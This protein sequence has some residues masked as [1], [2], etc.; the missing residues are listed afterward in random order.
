MGEEDYGL[1]VLQGVSTGIGVFDVTGDVI[2][3][4]FLN[5]GYYQMVGQGRDE[6][7]Q[8]FGN[9][10]V[11]AINP[12]DRPGLLKEAKAAIKEGREFTYRFRVLNGK[13]N[14]VW[15]GI[16]AN[17]KPLSDVTERFYAAYYNVDDLISQQER[18]R[19]YSE[20]RDEILDSI[21]GGVAIFSMVNGQLRLNYTN[22]GFFELH[23]GSREFLLGKSL[24]PVTWLLP[25]D[26]EL[27]KKEF[28]AVQSGKKAEG[29]VAYRV[30]GE[31]GKIHWV[32]NQFRPA[33]V[34]NGVPFF[35]ASFTDLDAQKEA[36][37]ERSK[38]RQMYEAAVEE[39]QLV[40]WEFD[41]VNHTLT[42]ADNDFT[43]YD[44][45]KFGLPKSLGNVPS[46]L[47]PFI[48]EAYVKDFLAMY[49]AIEAGAP[50]ASCEVWYKLEKGKEPRCEKISYTT[51]FD[52]KGHPIKAYGIGQN[53]TARKRDEEGYD[54]IRH[55]VMGKLS[56]AVSSTQ[57]NLSR[58]LYLEGYSPYP[59]VQAALAKTTA[60][61]HFAAAAASISDPAIKRQILAEFKCS[62]LLS[63]FERGIDQLTR[64]YPILSSKGE[65]LW[66]RTNLTM[67]QNPHT[68]EIEAIS[69]SNDV[70]IE[71]QNEE[72]LAH[73]ANQSLD[74]I[75][76][77]DLANQRYLME[78]GAW[79]CQEIKQG[80]TMDYQAVQ[81]LLADKY[82][83]DNEKEFFLSATD[84]NR[85]V[86]LLKEQSQYI[87]PYD[88]K[89][90][91]GILKKQLTFSFLG[92][93]QKRILVVQSDVTEAYKKDQERI[94]AL[95][96]AKT[97]ADEANRAKSEFLS[98]MSHDIRTPLNGIIGMSYLASEQ[99]NP[100]K[101]QDCLKKIDT[102]SKYLLSLIN[103]ILDMSKAESKAIELHPEPYSLNEFQAYVDSLIK[104]LCQ[105]KEQTFTLKVDASHATLMPVADKLRSNQ[106]I[107]NLLSNAVK[108]TP[109]GG[110]IAYT[111]ILKDEGKNQCHITHIVADDGIGMS[112]EFLK[113]LF[114]PFTQE[115]RVISSEAHGT[116]L[117]L[118][119]V[120]KL[121][122][123][124]GGTIEVKSAIGKGST[125]TLNFV[126]PAVP[127]GSF[128]EKAAFPSMPSESHLEHLRGKR[129][130]LCEDNAL[131]QEIMKAILSEKGMEVVVAGDGELGVHIFDISSPAYFDAIL[132]D[133]HM[134]KM[135]GYEATRHIRLLSREDAKSIPI[136][137]MTADAFAEDVQ[138]ALDAG[139][140]GHIAKPVDPRALFQSLLSFLS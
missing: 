39:G 68:G 135:D 87:L 129:I 57:L 50:K 104:P 140:N 115:N 80:E 29:D 61:E 24:N 93:E 77:I 44:Y 13:G 98:Q 7:K 138:K 136:I 121:V 134:P 132:M 27:F 16:R 75:G 127:A 97:K 139:M 42:M 131:N 105:A 15:V 133:I 12:E 74:F 20:E 137:A 111:V 36:E 85:L 17:H 84:L 94:K 23:H 82:L 109:E 54:R 56:D 78:D 120:K 1:E 83:S 18:L 48:D 19:R 125:F 52:D 91:S 38:T 99:E 26:Q 4:K 9:G 22:A 100:P 102:S 21:P 90:E 103:D 60:D 33:Y 35:Y 71:K 2:E 47:V 119:I 14:Y 76:V 117:G 116:G 72:I 43:S 73:L 118:A 41:I 10:V 32:N 37:E 58:N 49:R 31:D 5:D 46:S 107:F 25:E 30:T 64:T 95:E 114:Q 66:I 45:R 101:T 89:D 11:G 6:R 63:L 113:H 126:F 53:I 130:L 62:F 112:K 110:H 86:A 34:E 106:V 51:V 40:V 69:L 96:L 122:D 123:A 128:K 8:F 55:Q 3:M 70:T 67:M 81:H 65:L 92:E 28:E 59:H 88:F 79:K 124:M 108:Y